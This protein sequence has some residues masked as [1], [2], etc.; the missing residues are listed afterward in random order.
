MG[1]YPQS[2]LQNRQGLNVEIPSQPFFR[3][4]YYRD[5]ISEDIRQNPV[6]YTSRI[7]KVASIN[8]S[9]R[10]ILREPDYTFCGQQQS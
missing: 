6:K 7:N 10:N 3:F 2:I 4:T 5:I 9:D 8:Y 1:Y